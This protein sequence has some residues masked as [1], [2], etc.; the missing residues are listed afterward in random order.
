VSL[1]DF[2]N[3][4]YIYHYNENQILFSGVVKN[5]DRRIS[6]QKITIDSVS[7][8]GKVLL[9]L[10]LYPVYEYGN[11]LSIDC[12][13]QTPKTFDEFDYGKYLS[14]YRIYS[15]CYYPEVEVVGNQFSYNFITSNIK[16][17]LSRS[18]NLSVVEP[19][20]SILQALLLGNRRGI[21][22]DIL[23]NFSS[24]GL[25]HIIAI[26]G[27]HIAIIVM[28]IMHLS[29]SVGIIRQK[30]FWVALVL[31]ILYI[32]LIGTP[33]SAVRGATMALLVLYASKIGRLSYSINSLLFVA[34]IM[35]LFNPKLLLY[36]VGFQL[37]FMAV[38]GILY[39]SPIFLSKLK[40][41]SEY[42]EIKNILVITLSAQ[43]M[44][45]PLIVFYFNSV[46][47]VSLL[48]N[49][50]VL[51][52]L[53]FLMIF[54]MINSIIG[55]VSVSLGQLLGYIGYI[56]VSYLIFVSEKLSNLP[57]SYFEF[58]GLNIFLVCLAYLLI[59]IFIN[60]NRRHPFDIS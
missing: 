7:L 11:V 45:L 5:I 3:Q 41:V 39:L 60:R 4:D 14:R 12:Y 18:I 53:P 55:L 30:S 10:P 2:D 38:L 21:P 24:A 54:A 15:V 6:N 49:V 50:L 58:D 19:Q 29:M 34:F 8:K 51:P 16:S 52:V 9:T 20:S 47:I 33:A 28:I 59:F 13:L 56:M 37:S 43:I 35:L 44:T 32:I 17:K 22:E 27:M 36:D 48:S 46:S 57:F 31:I 42:G 23:N 25:S 40:N 1:P 26:S